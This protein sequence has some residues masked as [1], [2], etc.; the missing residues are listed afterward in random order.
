MKQ[1]FIFFFRNFSSDSR[2]LIEM[3]EQLY[4]NLKISGVLG[5]SM[6]EKRLL[7]YADVWAQTHR[8]LSCG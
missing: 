4:L 6:R 3:Y 8:N 1:D 2:L 5:I 7:G